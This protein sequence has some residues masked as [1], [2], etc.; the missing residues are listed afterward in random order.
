MIAVMLM[1]KNKEEYVIA[2]KEGDD[3]LS[4][5]D[6]FLK[7]HKLSIASVKKVSAFC[8]SKESMSCRIVNS[9]IETIKLKI[10][11]I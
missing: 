9:S 2:M 7:K 10:S 5:L 1:L 3:F 11:N 8:E 6:I 4:T